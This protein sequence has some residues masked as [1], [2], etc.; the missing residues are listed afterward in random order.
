MKSMNPMVEKVQIEKTLSELMENRAKEIPERIAIKFHGKSITYG[1]LD[2][3]VNALATSFLKIGIKENDRIAIIMPTRPEFMCA[4][5]AAS[6]IGAATVGLNFRYKQDE[7]TYMLN[8]AKPSTIICINEFFGTDYNKFLSEIVHD[9]PYLKKF[10]FLGK[11]EFPGAIDMD[12]LFE[13]KP[14]LRLLADASKK[15]KDT[16]DNF[17]I[18]TS[19]TTGKPKGAVLTQKSIIA[20]L[21]PWTRNFSLDMD[22]RLLGVLPLNHVG[23]GTIMAFGTLAC[24]ATLVLHDIFDPQQVIKILKEER[25]TTFGGVPTLFEIL[26]ALFP[27]IDKEA[28]P[29]IKLLAYGGA[30]ASPEILE[31]LKTAFGCRIMACYGSTEVSGFCTYTGKEDPYE[32]IGTAGRVP[33]GVE[34]KIVDPHKRTAMLAGEIGEI[35]VR[36]D[37]V[38]DRYLDMPEETKNAIDKDRW[39]YTGDLGYFDKDGFLCIAGRSKEMYICGGFNV[40]PMEIEGYL[41]KHPAV[42][43]AAVIGVPHKKMGEVGMAFIV[44]NFG[45]TVTEAEMT[46]Y[47]IKKMADYKVPARIFFEES[48]PMTALGKVQKTT[49]KE[50]A[51]KKLAAQ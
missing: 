23:G 16:M 3:M 28:L 33:E 41:A 37:M 9:L 38:F 4:W 40:Y 32:K 6:R 51:L 17:I 48:L 2:S 34:I 15:V 1:E 19:G 29:D 31:K 47:C 46:D 21:R 20:M 50:I 45:A 5:L 7:I 13:Q 30:P 12:T 25:I 11:T 27:D 42:A 18:F 39:F 35:A 43:M 49:L 26:F 8:F 24:G 10:I 36:S 14:D 44:K 22:D